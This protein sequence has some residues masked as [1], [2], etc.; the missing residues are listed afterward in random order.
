MR[1]TQVSA[2]TV[3][4]VA[5]NALAVLVLVKIVLLSVEVL[6]WVALAAVLALALAP[7][8]EWLEKRRIP[9][10]ASTLM[11]FTTGLAAL[12]LLARSFVP[13]MV[14][15]V[16]GLAQDLP[17]LVQKIRA[18]NWF[19][20]VDGRMDVEAKLQQ[21]LAAWASQA[22]MPVLD[23]AVNLLHVV[24]GAVTVAV[25][26]I[27]MVL[28]GRQVVDTGL[29]WVDPANRDHWR[30]LL[31]KMRSA[32]GGYVL[33]LL[34]LAGSD[35]LVMGV[36]A[37]LLGVPYYLPLGL[38]TAMLAAI[39][40]VG[41]TIAGVVIVATTFATQGSK[42]AWIALGVLLVYQQIENHVLM[43]LIQRRT[44]RMNPLL[45]ALALLVGTSAAG[46]FGALVAIPIAGVV[47]VVA[48]DALAR[49]QR[50]RHEKPDA[51]EP[52]TTEPPSAPRRMPARPHA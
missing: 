1:K 52:P 9:R 15:Q 13:L 29:K 6:Q 3:W 41:I 10:W 49:R 2:A 48:Q 37:L 51:P 39:P 27:F 23:V 33:G 20:W 42:D 12:V 5:L 31:A 50:R 4:I 18:S 7:V 35:G 28:F 26:T 16:R 36:T 14:M 38:L 44:I 22:A 17:S 46:V 47:Q 25:L 24:L 32:V 8:V 21:R 30:D 19:H 34:L 45:I 11:L 43:P 40:F